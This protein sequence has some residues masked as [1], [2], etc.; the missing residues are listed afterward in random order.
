M[1]RRFTEA[2]RVLAR[3]SPRQA[4][5]PGALWENPPE[6]SEQAA[7]PALGEPPRRMS[8][9]RRPAARASR[10]VRYFDLHDDYRFPER[11]ELSDPVSLEKVKVD[12][13]WQFTSGARVTGLGKLRCAPQPP[14]VPLDFSLAGAGLTPIVSARVA[15]IFRE[16]AP[17]D[18]QLLPVEIEDR[19]ERF[20]ILVATRL[21]RCIDERACTELR[22]YTPEDGLPER[23]GQYRTVRGL[24]VDPEK[25]AGARVFR[26]WGWPVSLIVSEGIKEALEHAGVTGAR[27]AEVTG[28]VPPQHRRKAGAKKPRKTRR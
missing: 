19:R 15:S 10:P 4:S 6:V 14:G 3:R 12:S 18:V 21:L 27:F 8:A 13:V 20:F 28:P 9:A 2:L 11:V 24:R 16:L 25:T 5:T 22:L 1:F 17:D 7:E 23:V 26:S